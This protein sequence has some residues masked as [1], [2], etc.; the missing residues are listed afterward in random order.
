MILTTRDG[1]KVTT[2]LSESALWGRRLLDITFD[3]HDIEDIMTHSRHDA[4][5][6]SHL[7]V[8]MKV[9]LVKT[10]ET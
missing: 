7:L 5:F 1:K 3:A 9:A 10:K 6:L 2:R 8:A 4:K